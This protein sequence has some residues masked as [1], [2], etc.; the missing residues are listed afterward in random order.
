MGVKGRFR[1]AGMDQA[2][3]KGFVIE[4]VTEAASRRGAAGGAG[5]FAGLREIGKAGGAAARGVA[6]ADGFGDLA[7]FDEISAV[8]GEAWERNP[9]AGQTCARLSY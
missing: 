6:V 3:A 8:G 7:G 9:E 4:A 2:A 5:G 1:F